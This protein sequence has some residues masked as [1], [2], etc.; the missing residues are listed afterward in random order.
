MIYF[1]CLKP[2]D[3]FPILSPLQMKG[4]KNTIAIRTLTV[5]DINGVYSNADVVPAI[6]KCGHS[7]HALSFR[8]I[9]M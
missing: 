2:K 3:L 6:K 7:V 1:K 5:S 9:K 8:N 4:N